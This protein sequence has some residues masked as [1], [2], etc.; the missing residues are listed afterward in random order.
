MPE[1]SRTADF[2]CIGTNDFVQ[3]M[4]GVDR[5]N[6]Q[7]VDYYRPDHPAV[8]RALKRIAQVCIE[9][10]KDISVCGEM[11]HAPEFVEF[12]LGIGIR[13]LSLDPRRLYDTQRIIEDIDIASASAQAAQLLA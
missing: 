2:F 3:Y 4:L 6:A 10:G 8:L 12:F 13:K 7:M 11:A 9:S 1:L 5:T